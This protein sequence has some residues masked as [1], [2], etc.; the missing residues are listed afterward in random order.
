MLFC[1]KH[2]SYS[3]NVAVF[4][5]ASKLSSKLYFEKFWNVMYT[6][7]NW[8][9]R[10]NPLQN[11]HAIYL[12]Q[13]SQIASWIHNWWK[14]EIIYES[15][16]VIWLYISVVWMYISPVKC[17]AERS[18]RTRHFRIFRTNWR[19]SISLLRRFPN[20]PFKPNCDWPIWMTSSHY[21]PQLQWLAD[22]FSIRIRHAKWVGLPAV[23]NTLLN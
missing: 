23:V 5:F 21:Y 6:G 15:F 14:L 3:D 13:Y 16:S 18:T 19:I 1:S 8:H 4:L 10:E 20:T 9:C 17:I 22:E 2:R 11:R 12:R 7:R